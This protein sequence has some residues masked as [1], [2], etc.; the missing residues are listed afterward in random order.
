[1]EMRIIAVTVAVLAASPGL[2]AD[3]AEQLG[4]V[5]VAPPPGPSPELVEMTG[6]LR[7][8]L[9]ERGTGV[10][11]G[12]VLRDR[13]AGHS[14]GASLGEL[15][16]AY[17]GAL[18]AYLNGDYE[19]SVR[20]LRA[21]IEDLEKLPDDGQV[22]S[23]WTRAMMRL[24]AT[25]LDLDRRDVAREV[26]DRLVHADPGVKVD[27]AQYP[28]RLARLVEGARS[29]LRSSISR[30]LSVASS[31][32]GARVFVDGRDVGTAPLTV[33][34]ARGRHR[35]S[36]LQGSVRTPP[37]QVDLTEEDRSVT[38]DFSIA[39]SLR[40]HLGPGL[41]L[42]D[43]ERARG[44][45]AAGGFLRLDSIVGT[46]LLDDAG[47]S[48]LLGS[49]YDV[50][51]GMLTREGRVRLENRA[52]P[53][54]RAANLAAFL[55]EGRLD[56]PQGDP[57][58]CVQQWP[59]PPPPLPPEKSKVRGWVAF[60]TGIAT[61]GLGGIGVWQAITSS[62]KY[63]SARALLQNGAVL[64]ADTTAYNKYIADGDS[65]RRLAIGTGIGAGV[66][67]VTTGVLGYLSYK[68]T[69]EIGPFR[70]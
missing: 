24:A 58:K 62:S 21:I 5:A 31:T 38:L 7:L 33:N 64:P 11:D 30:K 51:R 23:Q 68:Q 27:A 65:A 69:G 56:C 26:A 44:L 10:L 1:M 35:V 40:P 19:G 47:A 70:F 46:S 28:P 42:S 54:D 39:E 45:I 15:D 12:A 55:F 52:L 14:P 16:K 63:D 9:S 4:V 53:N 50:R 22:F 43:A 3:D 2:G 61:L 25:E 13:M 20:T 48:Y 17:D 37:L 18:A 32:K 29:E 49:R 8:K 6:Q 34:L 60:G 57:T 66:C 41:V 36:G 59:P 67:A